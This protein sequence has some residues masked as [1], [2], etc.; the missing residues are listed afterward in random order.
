M[1]RA[2][3]TDPLRQ[4]TFRRNSATPFLNQVKRVGRPRVQWTTQALESVWNTVR[5]EIGVPDEIYDR[6]DE[7]QAEQ[8]HIAA[9]LYMV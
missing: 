3:N 1:L 7:E 8:M 4:A 2:P 5:D 9:N 6:N